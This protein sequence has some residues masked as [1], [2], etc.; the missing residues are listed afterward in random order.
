[1]P[2]PSFQASLDDAKIS[3]KIL[4][5]P[6]VNT[7]ISQVLEVSSEPDPLDCTA[8]HVRRIADL[9]GRLNTL[10]R[11][12]TIA[13]GQAEKATAFSLLEDHGQNCSSRRV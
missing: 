1:L 13:M 5:L 6:S 7:V 8:E 11:H 3:E 10:K 4:D 2:F 9:E 12:T